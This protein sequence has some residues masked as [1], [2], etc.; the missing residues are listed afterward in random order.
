[1]NQTRIW[2]HFQSEGVDSF[3]NSAPRKRFLVERLRRGQ[4]VLNIGIGGGFFELLALRRRIEVYSLDPSEA[5]VK[6]VRDTLGMGDRAV[7]GRA[8]AAPFED[9][10]F[11]AIVMSEVLEH[12]DDDVLS[13]ALAEVRRL[14]APAGRF[15]VTVPHNENLADGA[16]VC[17]CCG[18][19][20]HRWG[21]VR[22]FDRPLLRETLTRHGFVVRNMSLQAFPDWRRRGLRTWIKSATRFVLGK[23]G[24]PIA[25]PCIF[26]E[27]EVSTSTVRETG[28]DAPFSGAD[29][30]P[31][32]VG[33]TRAF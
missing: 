4:R 28:V 15:L 6:R 18:E 22:S 29:H 9:R 7:I 5:A 31:A 10:Y 24:M 21:H 23:L 32:G 12:L 2:D 13:G 27:A 11:D 26:A 16:V 19:H 33:S 1:M 17:P 30:E 8:E 14:L 20:F 25:Q 3:R